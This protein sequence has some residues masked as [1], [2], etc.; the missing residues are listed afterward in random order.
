MSGYS[1]ANRRRQT[2]REKIA[3]AG[4]LKSERSDL[5]E[6]PRVVAVGHRRPGEAETIRPDFKKISPAMRELVEAY[7]GVMKRDPET[8]Y[9]KV[10][11]DE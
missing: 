11:G 2:R 6:A 8:L 1:R 7:S 5:K 10:C 4:N 3:A 9:N